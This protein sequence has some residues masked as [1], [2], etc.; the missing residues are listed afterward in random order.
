M[1]EKSYDVVGLG[2]S[3]IDLLMLV[4]HLPAEEEILRAEGFSTQGGGPVATAM[5]AAARAG[6]R[7]AMIDALGDDW[8][9]DAIVNGYTDAGVGTDLLVRRKGYTSATAVLLVRRGSGTRTIVWSPGTAPELAPDE[10]PYA[11]IEQAAY[12][13][14]NGRPRRRPA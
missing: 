3:T 8:R 1:P 7:V 13:H 4:D 14:V 5:V 9:G 2:V 11:A 6:G 12:L 10:I